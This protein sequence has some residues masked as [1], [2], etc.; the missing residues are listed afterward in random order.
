[1]FLSIFQFF[2]TVI[3]ALAAALGSLYYMRRVRLERPAIGR[4]NGRDVTILFV[5]LTVLPA[6]YLLL[7]RWA[8]TLALI[9]TFVAALHIGFSPILSPTWLWLGIGLLIGADLWMGQRLIYDVP[10][11]YFVWA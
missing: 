11:W 7:P 3:G 1:L 8:L 2:M 4:F 5:F 6:F 10:P 9:V